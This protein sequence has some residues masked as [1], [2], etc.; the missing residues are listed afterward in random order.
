MKLYDQ[1]DPVFMNFNLTNLMITKKGDKS[2]ISQKL[3]YP[4]YTL[5]K[6]FLDDYG[7]KI[8][9]QVM[10]G[11][12]AVT[13]ITIGKD[14]PPENEPI[15]KQLYGFENGAEVNIQLAKTIDEDCA[16]AFDYDLDS[17]KCVF[18]RYEYGSIKLTKEYPTLYKM[19]RS[20]KI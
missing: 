9:G 5:L 20:I 8:G 7:I 15:I 17:G 4:I 10:I 6:S 19:L 13:A 12:Y 11:E 2:L 1:Y 14:F 16:F 18:N 3:S